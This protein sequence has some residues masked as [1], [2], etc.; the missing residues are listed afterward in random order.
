MG[1]KVTL[2]FD[3]ENVVGWCKLCSLLTHF[4]KGCVVTPKAK[5]SSCLSELVGGLSASLC[6]HIV[7]SAGSSTLIFTD[8]IPK[9]LV[10]NLFANVGSLSGATD[11][12]EPT[13][14][15]SPKKLKK[16]ITIRRTF[17]GLEAMRLV[18]SLETSGKYKRGRPVGA[19]KKTSRGVKTR[20]KVEFG[21][22][23]LTYP[24]TAPCLSGK[25]KEK[26]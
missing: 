14:S 10:V 11:Y 12:C 13:M 17:P 3:Y 20:A 5:E 9:S 26:I 24:A 23:H 1:S 15:T 19:K 16:I 8:P 22:L 21:P 7:F 25:D 18:A 4:D 6:T 2:Y